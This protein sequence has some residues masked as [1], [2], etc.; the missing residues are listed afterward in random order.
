MDNLQYIDNGQKTDGKLSFVLNLVINGYPS[1]LNNREDILKK[2]GR[3][4]NLVI[5]GYPSIPEGK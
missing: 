2:E 4:L 1:I 3:V 5:N